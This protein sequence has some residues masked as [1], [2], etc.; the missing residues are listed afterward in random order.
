MAAATIH[1]RLALA[2]LILR[3]SERKREVRKACAVQVAQ[4]RLL[5]QTASRR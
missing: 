1:S 3:V 2:P 5:R 4:A